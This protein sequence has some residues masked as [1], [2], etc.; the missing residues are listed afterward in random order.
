MAFLAKMMLVTLFFSKHIVRSDII[1]SKLP[2]LSP[3][4]II[5]RPIYK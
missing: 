2:W 4:D 5:A 3:L 1:T